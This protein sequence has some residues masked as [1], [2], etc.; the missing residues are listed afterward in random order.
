M[1]G[2][3]EGRKERAPEVSHTSSSWTCNP[4]N[5]TV[6][7]LTVENEEEGARGMWPNWA[8]KIYKGECPRVGQES[9]TI[10]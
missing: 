5:K 1:G 9:A 2:K 3:K 4:D 8:K 10:F 7:C 6:Q